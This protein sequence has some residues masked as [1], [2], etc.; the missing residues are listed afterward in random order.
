MD[1]G[2]RVRERTASLRP[3]S[4]HLRRESRYPSSPG[5][6]TSELV[7]AVRR[8]EMAAGWMD[9]FASRVFA[10]GMS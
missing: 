6:K 1:E 7:R 4:D 8:E 3:V 10:L 5:V 9:I 2:F